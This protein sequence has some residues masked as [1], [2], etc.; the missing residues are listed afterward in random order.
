[1][2][3]KEKVGQANLPC[4]Y[5]DQLGKSIPESMEA[6]R[7]FA[8]E[9]CTGEIGPGTGFFTL[10]DQIRLN[11]VTLRP[12]KSCHI[13]VKLNPRSLAYWDTNAHNWRIDPGKFF[14][15]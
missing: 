13:T 8:A 7:K 2:T 11:S 12:G 9:T 3:L 5:V 14:S 4:V 15:M 1:M 6:V 10:E